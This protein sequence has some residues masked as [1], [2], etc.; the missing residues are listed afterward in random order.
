MRS[1][2]RMMA[3]LVAALGLALALPCMALAD[4][5][6]FAPGV[7]DP[8]TDV[9]FNKQAYSGEHQDLTGAHLQILDGDGNVVTEWDS[10]GSGHAVRTTLKVDTE[11]TLHETKAPDGYAIAPDIKFTVGATNN[12]V[13]V[14]NDSSCSGYY[15]ASQKLLTMYDAKV[16]ET[17]TR[18]PTVTQVTQ[19]A[20]NTTSN[21]SG[22]LAKT[23]DP[24]S[25]LPV[26]LLVVVGAI[27]IV[28]AVRRRDAAK[29][30]AP[31]DGQSKHGKR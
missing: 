20:S 7:T 10:D 15:V 12:S 30:E 26:V 4:T 9:T 8:V 6:T 23:N 28:V 21:G 18:V 25:I 22:L 17:V 27:L 19:P 3:A 2:K 5:Q 1:L 16:G 24:T 11:Y 29:A 31:A 14:T 13:T